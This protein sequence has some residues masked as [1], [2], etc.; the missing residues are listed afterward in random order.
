MHTK[1]VKHKTGTDSGRIFAIHI[2]PALIVKKTKNDFL[3]I[4]LLYQEIKKQHMA[5]TIKLLSTKDTL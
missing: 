5:N 3:K 2:Y 1:Q 4:D